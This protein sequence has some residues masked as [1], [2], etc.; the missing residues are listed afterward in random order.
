[1]IDQGPALELGFELD[2]LE[3]VLGL[4]LG[5]G[6][7]LGLDQSTYQEKVLPILFWC[8]LCY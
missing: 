7:D 5:L 1:M 4:R 3:L 8:K 6:S 2:N